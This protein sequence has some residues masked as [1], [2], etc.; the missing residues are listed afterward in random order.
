MPKYFLFLLFLLLIKIA[1]CT[2]ICEEGKN[3]CTKCDYIT[4]LCLKCNKDIFVPDQ[5][6][7][8]EGAKLCKIGNNYCQ[9]CQDN[10]YLC[11]KCEEGYFPDEN[12]GCSY[13]DNCEIAYK[14]ECIKCK[15]NYILVGENSYLFE[16]FILCKSVYSQD[17]KN[18]EEI[19]IRKG[20]CSKCKE[21][22]YLNKIDNRCIA[23][24]H[25]LESSYGECLQCT[26][27]YY[28]DKL[29]N[30]CKKQEGIF[31]YCKLTIDGKSCDICN[32]GYYFDEEGNC[33]EIN[34]CSKSGEN[35]KCEKCIT[36]YYLSS[37]YYKPACTKDQNCYQGDKDSGL[38]LQCNQNY[39]IDYKDGICKS[40]LENN[41]FIYCKEARDLCNSCINNYYLGEDLQCSNTKGCLESYNGVCN[42]CSDGYYLGLDNKCSLIKNCIYSLNEY[43][44]N[45]CRDGYYYN[46][47]NKSCVVAENIF[48]NCKI[49]I[50][51]DDYCSLCKDD[52]YLNRT[53]NLCYSNKNF[54]DFYKC[55]YTDKFGKICVSCAY[56]YYYSI[57]YHICSSIEGCEILK[58]ENSCSQCEENYCFDVKNSNCVDNIYSIDKDKLFYF[59]CNRTNEEGTA[60]EICIDNFELN[61]N[62]LCVD[63]IHCEEEKDG[64]CQKCTT[65]DEDETYHCLNN[66]FGCVE[67]GFDNC[68]ECNDISDFYICTKCIDGYEIDQYGDCV[69]IEEKK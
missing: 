53:D 36:G 47:H 4:Q 22:F 40:N 64:V 19:N 32:E 26:Y 21:G 60:C 42:I 54:G 11:K 51:G 14:G 30:K 9:E 58:D 13:T 35:G 7:G 56:N 55:S 50:N 48:K 24:E 8:C 34:F 65:F 46:E 33:T 37:L 49:V 23:T 15:N 66:Y 6:G 10:S 27:D 45:E 44:C 43:N 67:T 1:I 61:N 68:L 57:K 18:C 28:L 29:N 25:C 62:G 3:N 39:Y 41:E 69:K 31:S 52:F 38:C 5:N 63:K 16:G 20:I 59:R 17:F 12:G 2:P